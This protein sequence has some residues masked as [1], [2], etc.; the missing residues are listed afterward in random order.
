MMRLKT[1]LISHKDKIY[2]INIMAPNSQTGGAG[3]FNGIRG[4][5]KKTVYTGNATKNAP[6]N[7]RARTFGEK[8]APLRSLAGYGTQK[9]LI[10]KNVQAAQKEITAAKNS[11]VNAQKKN[12]AYD[13]LDKAY[14]AAVEEQDKTWKAYT[15][16]KSKVYELLMERQRASK[17]IVDRLKGIYRH[18][19]SGLFTRKSYAEN[20]QANIKTVE[21]NKK[22]L[23]DRA[24]VVKKAQE[25]ETNRR[26]AFEDSIK[27]QNEAADK[28]LEEAENKL[29]T[30]N[31]LD[32]SN[33]NS[34][35]SNAGNYTPPSSP[36]ANNRGK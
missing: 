4:L 29:N 17:N 2:C 34:L 18:G 3:F 24:A 5:F 7:T 33:S 36:R 31:A 10:A 1:E 11:L 6:K 12:A 25:D 14:K 13:T 35:R 30:A 9:R 20:V 21:A 27:E 8:Y 32:P 16:A 28:V 23:L 26:K 22:A 15:A 19:L